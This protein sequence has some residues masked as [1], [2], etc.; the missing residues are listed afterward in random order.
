MFVMP[1]VRQ[2]R[3]VLRLY[4]LIELGIAICGISI[5]T[6]LPHL[7]GAFI[8]FGGSH[9]FA[10]VTLAAACLLP[11]T[12]L[13]GATLPTIT[14][15]FDGDQ[16]SSTWISYCYAGSLAGGV[17]G[18]L[19]TG[20]YLLR[21]FDVNVTT[22][23]AAVLNGA[24][25][26]VAFLLAYRSSPT[27]TAQSQPTRTATAGLVDLPI[28]AATALSGAVALSA[29]IIWTR[30][31]SL[32]FGAT[33]Y[34]FSMVVALFLLGLAIGS[35][36]VGILLRETKISPRLMLGWCQIFSCV[37]LTFAAHL[38]TAVIPG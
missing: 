32:A 17:G 12:I 14:Q 22:W 29:E 16:R 8:R 27:A 5:P 33:V 11:P 25:S 2:T 35:A 37:G 28:Y 20:F 4:A 30:A 24:G 13:M 1:F 21:V 3:S 18:A 38:I 36:V 26:L 34:V 7:T 19:L 23:A 15:W 9:L 31:L 10:R 6:V